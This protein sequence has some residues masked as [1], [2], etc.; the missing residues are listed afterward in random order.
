MKRT[1]LGWIERTKVVP[2]VRAASSDDALRMAAALIEGGIDVLEITMTVSGAVATIR[3]LARRDDVLVGAGTVLDP[4]TAEACVEAGARF[5]VSPALDVETV[6]TCNRL[7]IVVAPG[8]LTP[9]EVVAAHRAGGDVIKIFPCDALGGA[10]LGTIADFLRAGAVG[11]G[12]ALVDPR[13]SHDALVERARA[14]RQ[15]CDF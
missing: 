9:T 10:T 12:S 4:A 1:V 3:E 6:R 13:L 14:F 11:V 2:V 5:V 8:A 15:A 7:G